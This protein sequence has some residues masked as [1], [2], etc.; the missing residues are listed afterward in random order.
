MTRDY[1]WL[2][3]YNRRYALLIANGNNPEQAQRIATFHADRLYGR[4]AKLI[5]LPAVTNWFHT[6]WVCSG[7]M[8]WWNIGESYDIETREE[9]EF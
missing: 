4:R 3:Q 8:G 5:I 9:I 1:L 7:G 6:K 2:D